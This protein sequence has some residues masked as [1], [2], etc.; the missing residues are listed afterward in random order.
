MR[1]FRFSFCEICKK[2]LNLARARGYDL[3]SVYDVELDEFMRNEMLQKM[4]SSR[5]FM[6]LTGVEYAAAG[7]EGV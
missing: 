2:E 7:G 5:M 3:L 6:P 4:I 1:K